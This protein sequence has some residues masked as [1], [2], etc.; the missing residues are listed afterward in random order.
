MAVAEEVNDTMKTR[1]K[2]ILKIEQRRTEMKGNKT[3][4][5][6]CL[7]NYFNFFKFFRYEK[8]LGT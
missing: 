4:T 7:T 1:K 3:K 5:K 6:F 2:R 8:K